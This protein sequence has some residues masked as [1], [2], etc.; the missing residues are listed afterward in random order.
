M[1]REKVNILSKQ[2]YYI[3]TKTYIYVYIYIDT[4]TYIYILYHRYSKTEGLVAMQMAMHLAVSHAVQV[5]PSPPPDLAG[6][7]STFSGVYTIEDLSD[8]LVYPRVAPAR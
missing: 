3:V 7:P 8:G 6:K 5:N 2:V 4:H 1:V